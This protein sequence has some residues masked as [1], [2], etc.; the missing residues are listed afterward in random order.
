MKVLVATTQK[1]GQRKS[2]FAHATEGEFVSFAMECDGESVD[3]RCGCRRSFAGFVSH[4]A[5]T[6]AMVVEMDLTEAQFVAAYKESMTSAGWGAYMTDDEFVRDARELLNLAKKVP[7]GTVIEK[8]G[9]NIQ[10]RV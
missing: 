6:T 10:T 5:T 7:V 9:V 3:G 1:Q 4:K 2:D 8:R